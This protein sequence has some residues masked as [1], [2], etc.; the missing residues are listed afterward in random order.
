[1]IKV[2][3]VGYGNLGKGVEAAVVNS[4]D[5]EVAGV[6]TRRGPGEIKTESGAPVYSYDSLLT[7]QADEEGNATGLP[8]VDVLAICGGSA[9]DLPK[10][11]PELAARYNVVDSFDTHANILE[12]LKNVG[13]AAESA[14]NIAIISTGWDPGLFSLARLYANAALPNGSDYTF[15]GRGVSQGHSDAIRRIDGVL[16]ARQY[17]VPIQE[18]VDRVRAGE[19]PELSTREKHLR[20]CY[21][22]VE[23]GADLARIENEI[24]S[25]PN[26]FDEYDTSVT[27][28][29]AE[30]LA[31]DHAGL[32]HGGH[33]I[34]SGNTGMNSEFGN[35]VEFS[36]NLDS[37]PHFTGSVLA[38]CARA[39]YRMS[40]AGDSGCKTIFDIPPVL[41]LPEEREEIIGHLL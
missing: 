18:A 12:H 10:M 28:I 19:N 4:K 29:S 34:R 27:F 7:G 8:E 32:P 37:N 17:T 23:E 3:I 35:T 5:M 11:T 24:V 39:A 41:L 22:V 2:G 38:A 21:V 14:G 40:Q 25:M 15:W 30:E 13:A 20:E 31:R 33:V 6:F 9:T 16:D 1:M 36:L 26:Y